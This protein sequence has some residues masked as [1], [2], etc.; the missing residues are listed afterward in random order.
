MVF[1]SYAEQNEHNQ[2]AKHWKCEPCNLEFET[3]NDYRI[4]FLMIK[5]L[6]YNDVL[7]IWTPIVEI[8]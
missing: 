8:I 4:G 7:I 1:T 5:I 6:E 2:N 3:K